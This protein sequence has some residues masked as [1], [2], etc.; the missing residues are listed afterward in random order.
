MANRNILNRKRQLTIQMKNELL[1]EK[2]FINNKDLKESKKKWGTS[3]ENLDNKIYIV[4]K[5]K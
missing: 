2:E 4:K 1:P 5:I 3:N